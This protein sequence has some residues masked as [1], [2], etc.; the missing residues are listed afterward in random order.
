MASPLDQRDSFFS[1]TYRFFD[2]LGKHTRIVTAI[3]G[4]VIV[5]GVI[6]GVL[7]NRHEGKSDEARN[8]L[9]LAEKTYDI[10]MKSVAG[11]KP[12]AP[13]TPPAAG[14]KAAAEKAAAAQ[15]AAS[16]DQA[17]SAKKMEELAYQKLDLDAKFPETVKKYKDVISQ[18][19]GTRA[20]HEARMGLGN[21]YFNH[22]QADKAL[23]YFKDAVDSAPGHFEKA[24]ALS[25]LGYAYENS[26]KPNEALPVFEKAL[27]LGEEGI[28]GDIWLAIA[29]CQEALHDTAKARSTYDQ[30]ITKL[31]TSDA[32]KSAEVLKAK[33]Q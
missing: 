3:V 21:L 6:G 13:L 5:V 23:P 15:K 16:A 11:V 20:A 1:G 12:P 25:A 10:E 14:D 22:A 31:P 8:S 32:A 4:A 19:S 28:K 2:G 18:Y 17:N 7:A 29:R 30:I 26:G 27:N 24:L 33:L 9:F